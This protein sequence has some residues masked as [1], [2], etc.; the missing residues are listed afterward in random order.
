MTL[1]QNNRHN[2]EDETK[3]KR[4]AITGS[5][6]MKDDR[7]HDVD[8]G[9]A[10]GCLVMCTIS[11]ITEKLETSTQGLGVYCLFDSGMTDRSVSGDNAG[12]SLFVVT[13]AATFSPAARAAAR[14]HAASKSRNR[15]T[16]HSPASASPQLHGGF[17]A[18]NKTKRNKLQNASEPRSSQPQ[19]GSSTSQRSSHPARVQMSSAVSNSKERFC[20][21]STRSIREDSLIYVSCAACQATKPVTNSRLLWK[22][23]A[24]S[25]ACSAAFSV[26]AVPF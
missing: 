10:K 11:L 20:V 8:M 17:P 6:S 22:M 16:R 25:Y 21:L 18:D 12:D 2:S 26:P 24:S 19:E 1:C 9:A 15:G 3:S 5:R 23:H 13:N 14:S 7:T 4:I